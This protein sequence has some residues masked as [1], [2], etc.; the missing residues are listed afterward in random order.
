VFLSTSFTLETFDQEMYSFKE[1]PRHTH[2]TSQKDFAR[3]IPIKKVIGLVKT[4]IELR[5]NVTSVKRPTQGFEEQLLE[6]T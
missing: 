6:R 5:C 3:A 4:L 1:G 2:T